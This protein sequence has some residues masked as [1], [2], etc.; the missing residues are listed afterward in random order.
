MVVATGA[1]ALVVARD[2]APA[3]ASVEALSEPVAK[4]ELAAADSPA[5]P[6][7]PLQTK[8]GEGA[9]AAQV[10]TPVAAPPAARDLAMNRRADSAPTALAHLEV[11]PLAEEDLSRS[12][13][14]TDD[15]LRSITLAQAPRAEAQASSAQGKASVAQNIPTVVPSRQRGAEASARFAPPASEQAIRVRGAA[16]GAAR[17]SRLVLEERMTE[18]G[19]DV[20]RL[21]YRVDNI[22][23]TLNERAPDTT[24]K[25]EERVR[26][27][28][29]NALAAAPAPPKDSAAA[30]TNTIRWT[31]ARG[32]EFTLSGPVSPARLEEIRK[33]L[34]Y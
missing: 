21:I 7:A 11:V 34:G 22:L 32:A 17:D 14:R 8:E 33:L 31:D 28:E 2:D 5:A 1:L 19:R 10:T 24:T 18:S 12:Q 9:R 25:A 27:V 13:A 16:V 29:L 6:P 23:V 3:P 15:T 26:R 30:V 20:R 4:V